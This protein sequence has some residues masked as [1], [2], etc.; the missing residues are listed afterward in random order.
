M[1]DHNQNWIPKEIPLDRPNLARIYDW[2]IGGYHNFEIDRQMGEKVVEIWPDVKPASLANR[3]FLRRAVRYIVQQG[4]DQLIDI[5]SGLP[6]VGNVHEIAQ[7]INPDIRVVYVDMDPVVIA[8]SRAMLRDNDQ[9]ITLLADA[10][11]TQDLLAREELQAFLDFDK[12]VGLLLFAL[13]HSIGNDEEAYTMVETLRESVTWGSYLAISHTT[14][15]RAPKD[16]LERIRML[17]KNSGAA[18]GGI[19]TR[20]EILTFFDDFQLV[21]PGLVFVPQWRPESDEDIF[22]AEPERTANLGGVGCKV[23]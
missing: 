4:V 20:E 11:Q 2:F 14:Y 5:G 13:L 15:D 3:A 10:R 16:V 23:A 19:R 21:P 7:A 17:Y 8:H 22:V 9:V 12:P 6:T 18:D 1:A